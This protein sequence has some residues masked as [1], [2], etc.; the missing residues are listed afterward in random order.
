[1]SILGKLKSKKVEEKV[2]TVREVSTA[3][4]L[5]VPKTDGNLMALVKQAWV[6]E[7]AGD[8]TKDGKY[9]FIVGGRATKPEIKKAIESI[10]DVHVTQVNV[11][12]SKGKTKRLGR[13]MGRTSRARKAI[14]TLKKGQK[15]D[16]MPT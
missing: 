16:I 1:M 6:T 7:R 13:S 14:V 8:L 3:A 12:N 15:I 4:S 10:Y 9:V 2:E 11:I 5:T